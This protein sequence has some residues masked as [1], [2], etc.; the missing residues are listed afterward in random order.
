MSID[1]LTQE[2]EN[3]HAFEREIDEAI[4]EITNITRP[5]FNGGREV[6]MNLDSQTYT[7]LLQYEHVYSLLI[8][9]SETIRQEGLAIWKELKPS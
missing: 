3:C 5:A 8:S 2:S 9:N 4:I 7:W 6:I 1:I